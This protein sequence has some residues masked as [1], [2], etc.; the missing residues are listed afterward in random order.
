MAEIHLVTGHKGEAHVSAKDVARLQSILLGG[1]ELI[2]DTNDKL[3]FVLEN[4]N[5]L[6]IKSGDILFQGRHI[7]IPKGQTATLNITNG[8]PGEKRID[9]VVCRYSLDAITGIETAE[10]AVKEGTPTTGT[11]SLPALTI[12]D[13]EGGDSVAEMLLYV[14]NLDG[15]SVTVASPTDAPPIVSSALDREGAIESNS[16][17]L[18]L[19][20]AGGTVT[21]PLTQQGPFILGDNNYGTTLPEPGTPGR[22]FFKKV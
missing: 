18:Y 19:K 3:G 6:K 9:A 20:K 13:I 5:T 17:A 11:P 15:I 10:L 8:T 21:G 7:C 14:V 4:A 12:G 2:L 16:D 1:D 22:V